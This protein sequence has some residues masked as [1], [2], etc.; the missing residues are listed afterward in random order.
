MQNNLT[1]FIDKLNETKINFISQ[2]F[3]EVVIPNNSFV[4]IDP[5]YLASTASYNEN[6]GW[7]A[8]LEQNLLDYMDDLNE[9]GIKFALSNVLE[10]KGSKNE[11]LNKWSKKYTVNYLNYSYSNCNYQTKNREKNST[12]E[13][14]ITNY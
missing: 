13:V 14:L 11:L 12:I 1:R 8:E 6:G 9:R 10:S 2:D 4:Y 7:S 5:P 3:R